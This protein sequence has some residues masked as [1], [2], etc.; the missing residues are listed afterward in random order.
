MKDEMEYC[1]NAYG[2]HFLDMKLLSYVIN[3]LYFFLFLCHNVLILTTQII[4][5][6]IPNTWKKH[7]AF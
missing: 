1:N 4:M 2:N 5:K 6:N 3:C 7:P